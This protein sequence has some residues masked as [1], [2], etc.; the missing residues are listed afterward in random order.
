MSGC[1]SSRPDSDDYHSDLQEQI[2]ILRLRLD[3]YE[4]RSWTQSREDSLLESR[5]AFI[6][7]LCSQSDLPVSEWDK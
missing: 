1:A 2:D 3:A 7:S 4:G 6:D 5:S